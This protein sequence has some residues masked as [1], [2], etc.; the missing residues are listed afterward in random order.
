LYIRGH[1]NGEPV[2]RMLIDGGAV[3]NLM[4]YTIFKKLERRMMSS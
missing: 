4:P 2:S 3:V 1:I